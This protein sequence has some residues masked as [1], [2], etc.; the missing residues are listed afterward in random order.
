MIASSHPAFAKLGPKLERAAR[1][2]R[3]L[4]AFL[5]QYDALPPEAVNAWGRMTA[6]AAAIHNVYNGIEDTLLSLAND[7][8][9]SVPT[10]E[11]SHQDLLDQMRAAVLGLRPPLLD[12]ALYVALTELKGFR[13]RVRHR[14]GFD[15]D[16]GKTN[17]SLD[18]MRATFPA[19]VE[20]VRGL[21][22]DLAGDPGVPSSADPA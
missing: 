17:E 1:E 5:G 21:E 6:I 15:L 16:P 13:H 9:G 11:T 2:L 18:R 3:N 22:R 7:I 19:Y 12:D 14:Y 10:G 4:D 8:D 20:A